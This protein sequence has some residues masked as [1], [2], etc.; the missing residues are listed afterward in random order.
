[1][2]K[3]TLGAVAGMSSIAL[4]VPLLAQIAGAQ[5]GGV[6]VAAGDDMPVPSQA[7]ALALVDMEDYHL[8]HFDEMMNKQKQTMQKH[9]DALAAAALIADDT[10]RQESL[11][12]ARAEMIALK[13]DTDFDSNETESLRAA[14]KTACGNIMMFGGKG[15]GP[16]I[17]MGKSEF[18]KAD[19]AEELGMTAQELKTALQS[20]KTIEDIAEEKGVELPARAMRLKFRNEK[21]AETSNSSAR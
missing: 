15:H 3:F 18:M 14:V 20:G 12:A 6:S 9:R 16:G 13:S 2:N 4:A 11:K 17:H 10:Q 1:M 5:S 7:C 8:A 19:I 21:P